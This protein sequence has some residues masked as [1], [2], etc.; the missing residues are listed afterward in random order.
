MKIKGE[1]TLKSLVPKM[2]RAAVNRFDNI[3]DAQNAWEQ[4][5][6]EVCEPSSTVHQRYMR[7]N[8][9]LARKIQLDDVDS[10]YELKQMVETKL[11]RHEWKNEAQLVAFRL[12]A[13]SFFFQ[14]S[15]KQA[16]E[17]AVEG[18]Y[19]PHCEWL[20]FDTYIQGGS[21]AGSPT[22]LKS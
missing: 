6:E 4:F 22:T 16:D 13:S 8:P 14:K 10:F 12:I 2:F 20:S 17:T 19:S 5:Y 11:K 3:L 1:G 15:V 21:N 18:K 9:V 7:L